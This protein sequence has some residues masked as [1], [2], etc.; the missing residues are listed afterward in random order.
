MP[1]VGVDLNDLELR[2]EVLEQRAA[3]TVSGIADSYTDSENNVIV[4]NDPLDWSLA[5]N[6]WESYA[7]IGPPI[8]DPD[9]EFYPGGVMSTPYGMPTA[10]RLGSM[11]VLT[12]LVRRKAGAANL[13]AGTR[14]NLPMFAL[15]LYW[16]PPAQII[17]PC[18]MGTA[19]PAGSLGVVGTAWIEIREDPDTYTGV[20]S[21]VAGTVG[22]AASTG[23]VALQ[24]LFPIS[25]AD[26]T[27]LVEGSWDDASETTTWDSFDDTVTWNS[28]PNSAS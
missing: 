3:N 14:Y 26:S 25:V 19:D 12:G 10:Y 16:Q 2:V 9:D 4:T 8:T 13:V 15:P 5:A 11:C 1:D 17:L 18:L 7:K 22:C 27:P 20:V 24:G 21:F 28:Y 23:W 6:G